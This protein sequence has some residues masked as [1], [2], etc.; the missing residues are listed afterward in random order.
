M[1]RKK[2]ST[3]VVQVGVVGVDSGQLMICDPSYIESEFI[4]PEPDGNSDHAHVIYQHEDGTYWQYCYMGEKPSYDYVMP[5]PGKY[6]EAIQKY[7]ASP[8]D[9]IEQKK[10]KKTNLDPTP[11]IPKGEFSYRGICKARSNQNQVGQ[12]NFKLGH[13]GV[14]VAFSSGFGDGIYEV[15]AEIV[16]AGDHGERYRGNAK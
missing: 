7:G 14:A 13:E 1:K 9:L 16:N 2:I 15:F 12:L 3:R 6:S 8:N 4:T 5:F 11:H 10:F